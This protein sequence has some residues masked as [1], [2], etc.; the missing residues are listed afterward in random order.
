VDSNIASAQRAATEA[1][2]NYE[3]SAQLRERGLTT[4]REYDQARFDLDRAKQEL[5][6]LAATRREAAAKLSDTALYAPVSGVVLARP[7]DR[8]Q[9]V[10]S[11]T[12]IYEI[13]PLA[14]V[15]IEAEV[16]EQFLG[17][18]REGM[19]ADVLIPGKDKPLSASL[20][21]IAPKVDPRTGGAKVRLRF[22]EKVVNLRSGLT[23]DINLIV[24]RRRD[25]ITVAR[26]A[27][28]GRD[29]RARVLVVSQGV[30]EARDVSFVDWPSERV[31]VERGLTSGD[32]LLLQPRGDLVGERVKGVTSVEELSPAD[33][34]RGSDARRA[35]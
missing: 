20:Y 12:V 7:V 21:Y 27:I 1:Q 34:P 15:E 25:A 26:S 16:D 8:G 6:R 29:Q 28:L 10:N 11:Q 22:S 14:D 30:V 23:A 5:S 3:R 9:A 33:R 35:I 4:V 31:I 19:A 24:E 32:K 13:A 18:I 17:T 2:R